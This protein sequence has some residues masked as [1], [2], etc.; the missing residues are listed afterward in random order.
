MKKLLVFLFVIA[1]MMSYAESTEHDNEWIQKVKGRICNY[2][3]FLKDYLH[4][5]S[6][7]FV[8]GQ[9][10]GVQDTHTLND[11]SHQIINGDMTYQLKPDRQAMLSGHFIFTIKANNKAVPKECPERDF[12]FYN[13]IR[14]AYKT[15][16]DN[17]FSEFIKWAVDARPFQ[18]QENIG[19]HT[20]TIDL[21][22]GGEY[23]LNANNNVGTSHQSKLTVLS[24]PICAM[25]VVSNDASGFTMHKSVTCL[26]MIGSGYPY[27]D[28]LSK[29]QNGEMLF[30]IH[31]ANNQEVAAVTF[32]LDASVDSLK[33]EFFKK[34]RDDLMILSS[35]KYTFRF[36]GPL[37]Q[38]DIVIVKEVA[39][40]YENLEMAINDAEELIDAI[41]NNAEF[42]DLEEYAKALSDAVEA[43]K[44]CL[45]LTAY[46]Q[47]AIDNATEALATLINATKEAMDKA[48]IHPVTTDAPKTGIKKVVDGEIRIITDERTFNLKG[49]EVK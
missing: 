6:E 49:I 2:K 5:P 11:P 1:P 27:T 15:V 32:K 16:K 46:E 43:A 38:E 35:P 23:L 19:D 42:A 26:A 33:M 36:S 20:I 44:P 17:D 12:E 30:T 45:Q 31:D 14:N 34:Y 24:D 40:L 9:E 22:R 13:E 7:E 48:P 47:E 21:D 28:R 29:Y 41:R 18:S 39:P 10:F 4:A 25:D 3:P 8:Y 37:L